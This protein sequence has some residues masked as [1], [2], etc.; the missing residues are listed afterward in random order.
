MRDAEL[1]REFHRL[2]R[3]RAGALSDD[4]RSFRAF[5]AGIDYASGLIEAQPEER[6][7]NAFNTMN[8]EEGTWHSE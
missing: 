3:K 5:K 2:C 4:E 1:R 7:A 6:I 8:I